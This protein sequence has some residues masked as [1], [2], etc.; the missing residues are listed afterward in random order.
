MA[1]DC[2]TIASVSRA[3]KLSSSGGSTEGS[4]LDARLQSLPI[5]V[6]T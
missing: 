6:G 1:T 2:R 5:E 3:V 4:G